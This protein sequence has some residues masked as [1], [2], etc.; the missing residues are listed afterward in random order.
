MQNLSIHLLFVA[1]ASIPKQSPAHCALSIYKF[2]VFRSHIACSHCL[3]SMQLWMSFC[4][5]C[6]LLSVGLK[7]KIYVFFNSELRSEKTI[8]EIE[9]KLISNAS[10]KRPKCLIF[11]MPQ[12]IDKEQYN[13]KVI[14]LSQNHHKPSR[15]NNCLLFYF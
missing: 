12:Y 13:I 1:V 15:T 5:Q 14:T 10:Q 3:E 9:K 4:F 7:L 8:R 2:G 11:H 6:Q